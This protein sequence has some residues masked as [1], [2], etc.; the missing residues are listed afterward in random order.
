MVGVSEWVD[1]WIVL[2]MLNLG[3]ELD[4]V[5][6]RGKGEG[7]GKGKGLCKKIFVD[8]MYIS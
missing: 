7:K 8:C 3:I 1:G 2:L 4:F 6:F 5:K